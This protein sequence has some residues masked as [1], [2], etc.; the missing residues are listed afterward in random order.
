MNNIKL[1]HN[2][3]GYHNKLMSWVKK[4]PNF[5]GVIPYYFTP[6]VENQIQFDSYNFNKDENVF[7]V[8]KEVVSKIPICNIEITTDKDCNIKSITLIISQNG[9]LFKVISEKDYGIIKSRYLIDSKGIFKNYEKCNLIPFDGEYKEYRWN[10]QKIGNGCSELN[11]VFNYN[12]GIKNGEC[13]TYYKGEYP[14][15][16]KKI[17]SNYEE[18]YW[19]ELFT[20]N[21]GKKEGFY[22]NTKKL[23]RGFFLNGKRVGEWI[24][25][26]PKDLRIPNFNQKNNRSYGMEDLDRIKCNYV[27]SKLDGKWIGIDF[28][29]FFGID[30]NFGVSK[31]IG[32]EFVDGKLDGEFYSEFWNNKFLIINGNFKNNN[33]VGKWTFKKNDMSPLDK[34]LIDDNQKNKQWFYFDRN[35][36]GKIIC[37]IDEIV[38]YTIETK[39]Y[40]GS[41]NS[42]IVY[43][44]TETYVNDEVLEINVFDNSENNKNY[45]LKKETS[46]FIEYTNKFIPIEYQNIGLSLYQFNGRIL[47][48]NEEQHLSIVTKSENF[49]GYKKI[50]NE[51]LLKNGYS[52][53]TIEKDRF[54]RRKSTLYPS[55]PLNSDDFYKMGEFQSIEIRLGNNIDKLVSINDE[56]L[57]IGDNKKEDE[58]KNKWKV[59]KLQLIKNVVEILINEKEKELNEIIEKKSKEFTLFPMD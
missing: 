35:L 37:S 59:K 34:R 9:K 8:S 12:N 54:D 4:Q 47:N 13:R 3:I 5:K 2:Q 39:I 22:E 58:L 32:G 15:Y 46:P 26:P 49:L 16:Y 41:S 30:N 38:D 53:T 28:Y 6:I 11:K 25:E 42:C 23:E 40:D 20:Y 55:L 51:L 43:S 27:N 21:F 29:D 10:N 7:Y 17:D 50:N 14:Y 44:K 57:D 56:I 36:G 31:K 48:N 1:S 33:E 18:I 19:Y 52:I 45:I 24:V